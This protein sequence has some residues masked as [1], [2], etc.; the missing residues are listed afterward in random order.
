MAY[1]RPFR[2]IRYDTRKFGAD[3]SAQIAPPYDVLTAADKTALLARSDR[4]IVAVDLPHVP[5]KTAGPDA[6]YAEAAERLSAWRADGTLCTETAPAVYRYHQTFTHAGRTFTRRMLAVRLRLERYGEGSIFPHEQTFPGPRADRLK[7]MQA[8]RCNLSPVFAMYTDPQGKVAAAWG[9]SAGEPDATG[10][11]DGVTNEFWAVT[12]SAILAKVTA[13]VAD[14]NIYIADGHHR[15]ETSL[16]YRDWLIET[17][18]P[19]PAD[20]PANFL[21]V[22]LCAMEDAGLL[23]LPTHR[24]VELPSAFD[25]A[26]FLARVGEYFAVSH[27]EDA[28]ADRLAESL[29]TKTAG[30]LGLYL[31]NPKGFHLLEPRRPDVL[32]TLAPQ[33]KPAWRKLA[34]AALHRCL[35]EEILEPH[36]LGGEPA[37]IRYVKDA[38][39]AIDAAAGPGGGAAFLLP[40]IELAEMRAVCEAGEVTPQ[41][42]TYFFPKMATGLVVNPLDD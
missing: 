25:A 35:I 33:R 19:I 23:V 9:D 32:E 5:P 10:T 15:Y 24:V 37:K 34:V 20:H 38:R 1:I 8:T 21:L 29:E 12:D 40:P 14:R 17:S 30:T 28:D 41:K 3:L 2:G 6:V 27:V 13:A 4:N 16:A 22:V 11:I 42:S 26:D 39:S 31:H 36:H 7:L 18:G